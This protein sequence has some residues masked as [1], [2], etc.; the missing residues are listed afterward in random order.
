MAGCYRVGN[1]VD[2]R[3]CA[4]PEIILRHKHPHVNK[5]K[6]NFSI[7]QIISKTMPQI[8]I[9]LPIFNIQYGH[10]DGFTIHPKIERPCTIGSARRTS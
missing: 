10:L 2:I 5:L 4:R 6:F 9:I 7:S 8:K 3:S 1:G